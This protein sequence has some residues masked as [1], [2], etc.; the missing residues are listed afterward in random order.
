MSGTPCVSTPECLSLAL[1]SGVSEG[2]DAHQQLGLDGG[3]RR[4]LWTVLERGG[5][6]LK[7]QCLW[8]RIASAG[9]GCI[10]DLRSLLLKFKKKQLAVRQ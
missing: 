4:A 6:S 8:V 9:F 2:L 10:T 3:M 1:A 7:C 5:N